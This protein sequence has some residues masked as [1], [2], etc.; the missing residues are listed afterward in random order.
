MACTKEI[1]AA[2]LCALVLDVADCRRSSLVAS[3]LDVLREVVEAQ[4]LLAGSVSANRSKH[5]LH[6]VSAASFGAT[7]QESA[8]RQAQVPTAVTHTGLLE[9]MGNAVGAC[10]LGFVMVIF[11]IP[12]LFFNERLSARSE[13]LLE[14]AAAQCRT[15]TADTASKENRGWLVHL[16]NE[17]LIPAEAVADHRFD[18]TLETNCVRLTSEIEIYQ[19]IEHQQS[20]TRNKLGGGKETITTYNY[21][22]EWSSYC[23]DS[24]RFRDQTHQNTPPDG[25]IFGSETHE[26][27]RVE[28]GQGFLLPSELVAQCA[29]FQPAADRLGDTV[30]LRNGGSLF[31]RGPNDMF[32]LRAGDNRWAGEGA[33]QAGD[34]RVT[35]KYVAG[36][37]VS[38]I[39][40]QVA[41]PNNEQR[42]SFAPY[43]LI[44]RP[45]FG[46]MKE[47]D[48]KAALTAQAK[49]SMVQ[50][51]DEDRIGG[52]LFAIFCCAFACVGR[53]CSMLAPEVQHVFAGD[54]EASECVRRIAD[55][56]ST[57]KWFIRFTG[58]LMMF[59]G[60]YAIFS[61]L[62]TLLNV[63]PFIG[64]LGSAAIW[65][66]C[67]LSTAVTAIFVI[68][69]A[70]LFYNPLK[71]LLTAIIALKIAA[72]PMA[73]AVLLGWRPWTSAI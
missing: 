36:G 52:E 64:S 47:E 46:G 23:I 3:D 31:C 8:T 38:I 13:A 28:V 39:A 4:A 22:Q 61:P 41:G 2:V 63:I 25:L 50:L 48:E 67:F 73:I 55:M 66:F 6:E 72:L 40:L 1:L 19:W 69:F 58:W 30:A 33:P 65:V 15:V 11:S 60:L 35:F 27:S 16:Q 42:D 45:F 62:I 57:A 43:R 29:D 7:K 59:V 51:S 71:A 5:F 21:T 54:V 44:S 56:R 32:Y 26:C 17:M 49:K 12:V 37:R 34:T 20:Q 14:R 18:A 9:E 68:S 10:I 53:I 24:S 70:Y